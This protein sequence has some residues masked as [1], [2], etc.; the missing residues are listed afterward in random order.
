MMPLLRRQ[1]GEV[2]YRGLETIAYLTTLLGA[3][4]DHCPNVIGAITPYDAQ[5]LDLFVRRGGFDAVERLASGQVESQAEANRAVMIGLEAMFG[6]A[7]CRVDM[8]GN[9][10]ACVSQEEADAAAEELMYS[11][12]GGT[13][14]NILMRPYPNRVTTYDCDALTPQF[15]D[16]L[17]EFAA[18]GPFVH[19]PPAFR[20]P[21]AWQFVAGE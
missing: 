12:A 2:K 9:T 18:L 19:P 10:T 17:I 3:I 13:D 21:A 7:G 15:M 5:Q 6:G 14:A 20:L 4:R 8:F 16:N 1:F 11:Y